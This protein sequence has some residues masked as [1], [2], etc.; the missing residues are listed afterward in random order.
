MTKRG[1]ITPGAM[2]GVLVIGAGAAITATAC[3]AQDEGRVATLD[4]GESGSGS[5]EERADQAEATLEMVKCLQEAGI[6]EAVEY[7]A[8]TDQAS[9]GIETDEPYTMR[10]DQT[11]ASYDFG[12]ADTSDES[13][14]AEWKAVLQ[15][16]EEL[17]SAYDPSLA[18]ASD[19]GSGESDTNPAAG[20]APLV[21]PETEPDDG[22]PPYLFIGDRDHTEALTECLDET[23]YTTP[24]AP[25]SDPDQELADKQLALI[26]TLAWAE[27]ARENGYPNLKDPDPPVANGW[28]T[29]ISMVLLPTNMT[30]QALRDLMA[31]CPNF[32]EEA[33]RS[34]D[35]EMDA[36]TADG[37]WNDDAS[38]L[39]R[40]LLEKY[41][42]ANPPRIGFDLPGFGPDTGG[43]VVLP[44]FESADAETKNV[45][46]LRDILHER[47]NA[48]T[49][50]RIAELKEMD[51]ND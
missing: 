42:T 49:D 20:T 18:T 12:G 44:D 50:Q 39:Y 46:R 14:Q 8:G 4:G 40:Q 36:A 27:C 15:H 35:H 34:L 21:L 29:G 38:P 31:A 32:D 1:W 25:P 37:S 28:K 6:S 9:F 19:A 33:T 48:Y 51:Q 24:V 41:P 23:G 10:V 45:M 5:V 2:A 11:G 22:V 3:T 30:E 7:E 17:A 26:P 43:G 47:F 13:D 16:L